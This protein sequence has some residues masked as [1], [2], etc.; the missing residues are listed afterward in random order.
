MIKWGL[1]LFVKEWA[2]S[3]IKKLFT[4]AIQ[5]TVRTEEPAEPEVP[6]AKP[7]EKKRTR[8]VKNAAK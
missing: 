4:A 2:L 8:K 5:E 1:F 3:L 7:A 6:E